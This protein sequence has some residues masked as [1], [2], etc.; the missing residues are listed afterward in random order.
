MGSILFQIR[1]SEFVPCTR[2][3]VLTRVRRILVCNIKNIDQ[4]IHDMYR[5]FTVLRVLRCHLKHF[6]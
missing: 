5:A 6:L 3:F 1:A 2:V 4:L